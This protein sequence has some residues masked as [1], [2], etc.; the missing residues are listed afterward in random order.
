[1]VALCSSPAT[2]V[3]HHE[4]RTRAKILWHRNGPHAPT[5]YGRQT[6]CSPRCS[7]RTTRSGSAP[8]TGSRLRRSSG[9]G[10][11]FYR[12][13]DSRTA[14]RRSPV[15]PTRCSASRA[16]GLV[17]TLY[18][19]AIF[20]PDLF[21]RFNVAC[22]TPVDHCPPPPPA[23]SF[24]RNSQ[25]IPI[26][27]SRFGQQELGEF[28]PLYVPH[29]VD[30]DTFKPT[31]SDV[32]EQMGLPDD[33][34][35]IGMVAAN[36]GRPSRKCFQQAFEA[37]RDFRK[38]PRERLPL[39]AHH[40]G[41]ELL[42]RRGHPHPARLAR[43]PRRRGQVPEPVFDDVRAARR[44]DD[45]AD[46]LVLRRAA[47]LLGGR[48][49]RVPIIEAAACGVPSIVTDFSAMPEVAG[50]SPWKV[51]GSSATGPGR[52]VD[53]GS[54]RRRDGRRA[55]G[56]LRDV[57]GRPRSALEAGPRARARLRRAEGL[58]PSTWHRRS[59]RSRTGSGCAQPVRIAA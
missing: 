54:R 10:S 23:I 45:G 28:D 8:T 27:M 56:V 4:R 46:L 14:T 15:T 31:E 22:W 11:P 12:D 38:T 51:C 59:R 1:M 57:G 6:A 17:I 5:G 7:P 34:F 48:G 9:T 50:P 21:K 41:G 3:S 43:D 44:A 53:A 16:S 26:A 19:T 13:S 32:R 49:L 2:S 30:V 52:L 33:A 29:G 37:F 42:R 47:Q 20:D 36:K 25:A 58:S 18:D 35:L 55:R 39:P 24:F 40:P